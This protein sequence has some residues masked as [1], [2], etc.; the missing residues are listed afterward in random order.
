MKGGYTQYLFSLG[1]LSNR[2]CPLLFKLIILISTLD[3]IVS[4]E[5]L[6]LV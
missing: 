5:G 3:H 2:C 4:L 6:P 1:H